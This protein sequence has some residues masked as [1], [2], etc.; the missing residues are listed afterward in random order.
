[1]RKN[2]FSNTII[3]RFTLICIIVGSVSIIVMCLHNRYKLNYHIEN[4]YMQRVDVIDTLFK[5]YYV[6]QISVDISAA[7]DEYCFF[8]NS[9]PPYSEGCAD[10]IIDIVIESKDHKKMNAFIEPVSI[11]TDDLEVLYLYDNE[12]GEDSPIQADYYYD[13]KRLM[14]VLQRGHDN[15]ATHHRY[16]IWTP[17]LILVSMKK[18][19][20]LP[21][22]FSVRFKDHIIQG[23]VNNMSNSQYL[24]K[25]FEVV[26]RP[27]TTRE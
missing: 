5:D 3:G 14:S 2:V 1:M 11:G 17:G 20:G 24:L 10:S 27:F 15:P 9:I 12:T 19:E 23:V 26:Q 18:G 8:K 25:D 16:N 22:T 6:Y 21:S 7:H 13:L 4:V